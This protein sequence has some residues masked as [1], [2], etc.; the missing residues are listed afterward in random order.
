MGSAKSQPKSNTSS[1]VKRQLRKRRVLRERNFTTFM[2]Y[3]S[4]NG[5]KFAY[6]DEGEGPLV[7]LLHGFPD[8]AH[9]WSH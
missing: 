7:V 1:Y 5:L 6:L 9:T 4:A 8:T 2:N 3:I